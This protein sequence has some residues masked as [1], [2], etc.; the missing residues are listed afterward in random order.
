MTFVRQKLFRGKIRKREG[1]GK[2]VRGAVLA[3]V[4]VLALAPCPLEATTLVVD[5]SHDTTGFFDDLPAARAAIDAAA[6]DLSSF[7]IS[8]LIGMQNSFTGTQGSTSATVN[9]EL[10]Y[11]NPFSGAQELLAPADIGV[12]EFRF[13]AGMRNLSGT[14]LG[15]GGPGGAGIDLIGGGFEHE[16]ASAV[17]AMEDASNAVMPRGDTP[18]EVFNGTLTLGSVTAP[19]ELF[20]GLAVGHIWMDWDVDNSGSRNTNAELETYWHFDH[21]TPV[22]SGK[23]DFYSVA[24]HELM[25][26]I[27]FGGSTA[28]ETLVNGTDWEGANVI[29]LLGSG[30]DVLDPDGNHVAPGIFSLTAFGDLQE[31]VMTASYTTGTRRVLT[32]LDL[33]F[34]ADIGWSVAAIPEPS[35]VGLLLAAFMTVSLARRKTNR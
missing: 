7:L 4:F 33:A 6:D 5:Y 26:G 32:E 16:W 20:Y 1:C 12:D 24:L 18:Q 15:Q 21:T 19:Y 27:G 8:G 22:E 11:S 35:T 2:W 34:L 23:R 31:S 14:T 25:H 17:Q 30:T 3:S 29:N 28:W 10:A 9:W 13:Y